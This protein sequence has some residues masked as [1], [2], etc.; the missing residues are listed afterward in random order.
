MS[1]VGREQLRR[2]TPRAKQSRFISSELRN[3]ASTPE[4]ARK[5]IELGNDHVDIIINNAGI[6]PFGPT[7]ETTEELFEHVYSLNVKPPYFLV[8]ELAPLMA[9]RGEGAIP[10]L[11]TKVAEYGALWDES[12]WLERE[13]RVHLN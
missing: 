5:A 9:K 1:S 3:A 7:H 11:W 10:N 2:F 6:Y 12:L 13:T 8:A 4:V